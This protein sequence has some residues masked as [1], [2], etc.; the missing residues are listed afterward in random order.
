MCHSFGDYWSSSHSSIILVIPPV[1]KHN[2]LL[3]TMSGTNKGP[4]VHNS[5]MK[6]TA[7]L[8]ALMGNR[9]TVFP[10]KHMSVQEICREMVHAQREKKGT[11]EKL[12]FLRIVSHFKEG[13]AW[14]KSSLQQEDDFFGSLWLWLALVQVVL[15]LNSSHPSQ[16]PFTIWIQPLKVVLHNAAYHRESNSAL[17]KGIINRLMS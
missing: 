8:R 12:L 15:A 6:N 2:F 4:H 17:Y 10:C 1:K 11:W 7:V 14:S 9:H 16:F 13:T 5:H 3:K